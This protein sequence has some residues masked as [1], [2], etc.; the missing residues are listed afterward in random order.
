MVVEEDAVV[1]RGVIDVT[2]VVAGKRGAAV[3]VM[4]DEDAAVA[5]GVGRVTAVTAVVYKGCGGTRGGGG[6]YD[7]DR[8]GEEGSD[9]E[10]DEGGVRMCPLVSGSICHQ[11]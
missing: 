8:G 11:D 5:A 10:G 4:V 2:A 9:G 3:T 7:G 1:V 6:G